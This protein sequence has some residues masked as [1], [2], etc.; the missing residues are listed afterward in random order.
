[1][2]SMVDIFSKDLISVDHVQII[3]GYC[4]DKKEREIGYKIKSIDKKRINS[5]SFIS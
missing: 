1:M 3:T 5:L 4:K 2:V